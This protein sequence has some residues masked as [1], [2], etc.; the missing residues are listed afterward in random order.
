MASLSALQADILVGLSLCFAL[1]LLA[2]FALGILSLALA[3]VLP[4]VLREMTKS[5]TRV[6]LLVTMLLQCVDVH[7]CC[8]RVIGST[9]HLVSS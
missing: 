8:V 3:L 7:R 6:A 1:T 4:T 5:S 2:T 9:S